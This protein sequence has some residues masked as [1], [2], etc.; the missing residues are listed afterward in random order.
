MVTDEEGSEVDSIEV[1][2]DKDKL[3]MVEDPTCLIH[4]DE[5]S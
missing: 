2:R 3:Y 1:I 4:L 5:T